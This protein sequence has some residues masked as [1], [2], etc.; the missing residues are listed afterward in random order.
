M[1]N[2]AELHPGEMILKYKSVFAL[3][4]ETDEILE[5]FAAEWKQAA[6][7]DDVYKAVFEDDN[8]AL[9]KA[10]SADLTIARAH[11]AD[12]RK[13]Y[14]PDI[15]DASL[16]SADRVAAIMREYRARMDVVKEDERRSR[17]FNGAWNSTPP[18]GHWPSPTIH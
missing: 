15:V 14:R 5:W 17:R 12:L 10:A 4:R 3:R 9:A 1:M 16:A 8:N 13:R 6:R 11:L 18:G 7:L 2:I